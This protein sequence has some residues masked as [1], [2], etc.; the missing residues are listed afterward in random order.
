MAIRDS[1]GRFVKGH[2]QSNTGK[3]HF[4]KQGDY[5]IDENGYP[6]TNV[7]KIKIRYHILKYCEYHNLDKIPEGYIVHHINGNKLDYSKENLQ[8]MTKK[9]HDLY[10]FN[11]G[12]REKMMKGLLN[13]LEG[14][15]H[16]C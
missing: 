15:L 16:G 5:F 6:R 11:N 14:E 10:H 1:K 3:T 2:T 8:M 4:K 9:E 13:Y 12:R 7:G